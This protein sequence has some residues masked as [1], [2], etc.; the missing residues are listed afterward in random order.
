MDFDDVRSNASGDVAIG[1]DLSGLSIS[2]LEQRIKVLQAEIVRT[3]AERQAKQRHG[4]CDPPRAGG[5]QRL[6]GG[7]RL[8]V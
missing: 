1:S 5:G 6:D 2:E 8:C 3:E 7:K 4:Q